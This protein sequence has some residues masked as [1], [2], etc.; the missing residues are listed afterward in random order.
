MTKASKRETWIKSKCKQG[1]YLAVVEAD[2]RSQVDEFTLSAYGA[3]KIGFIL[4]PLENPP[5]NFFE[6]ILASKAKLRP[7]E[8]LNYFTLQGE[9]NICYKFEQSNDG[10]GY[11]Y[12]RNKSFGTTM[13]A[14][15]E[16][17]KMENIQFCKY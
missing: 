13:T 17:L 9:P 3:D 15:I 4:L 2:W 16:I 14:V 11:F 7:L 6:E 1:R 10:F 5:L 8:G 12:F